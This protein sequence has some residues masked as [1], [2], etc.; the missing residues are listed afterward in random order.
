M[1]MKTPL[2]QVRGTGAAR[3]GA[4]HWWHER[5]SSLGV[6]ILLVWLI[7]S[8]L[9]LPALDH[10]SIAQWLSSP[11]AAAPMLLLVFT[12][13][14]HL[15]MGLIVVIEDYVHEEGSRMFWTTMVKFAAVGAGTLAAFSV[16]KIAL[17][18]EA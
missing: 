12:T 13:F 4:G 18:G 15:Q 11:L 6:L 17:G 14:W 8:L 16:L 3:E 7:V 9:R 1:T 2:G 10:A 5:M